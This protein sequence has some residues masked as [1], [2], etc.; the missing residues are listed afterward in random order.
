[1]AAEAGIGPDAV[2]HWLNARG[3]RRCPPD[4]EECYLYPPALQRLI[5]FYPDERRRQ[6]LAARVAAW[7]AR[8]AVP[9]KGRR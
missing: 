1:M 4:D 6:W 7:C 8:R 2:W 9:V 5:V 3:V